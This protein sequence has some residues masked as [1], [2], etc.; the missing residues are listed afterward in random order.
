MKDWEIIAKNVYDE[1]YNQLTNE[2]CLHYDNNLDLETTLKRRIKDYV[3]RVTK[4]QGIKEKD[5]KV[6]KLIQQILDNNLWI[7][8]T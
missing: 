1:R 8:S 6:K 4:E 5:P 3:T 7:F 2:I